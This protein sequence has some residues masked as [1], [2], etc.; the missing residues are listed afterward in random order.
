[1]T[2]TIKPEWRYLDKLDST[3]TNAT[4]LNTSILLS[5][6]HMYLRN[7]HKYVIGH[8]GQL[9]NISAVFCQD[10]FNEEN[11][12]VRWTLADI[13]LYHGARYIFVKFL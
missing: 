12:T 10:D 5:S 1:M 7:D 6:E 9:T 11:M 4:G 2:A 8:V 13:T 3:S